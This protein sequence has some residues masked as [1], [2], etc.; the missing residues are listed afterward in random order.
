MPEQDRKPVEQAPHPESG[1]R[2]PAQDLPEEP[3]EEQAHGREQ[4]PERGQERGQ[5]RRRADA[6]GR[7][8]RDAGHPDDINLR[9]VA[10][11]GA[12]IVTGIVFAVAVSWFGLGLLWPGHGDHPPDAVGA[13]P[14][15]RPRLETA[16]QPERAAYDREK[17]Q[18]VDGYGWVDREAGI[19]RIPVEQAM[20]LM[21]ARAQPGTGHTQAQAQ[22]E[23]E[24]P[25]YASARADMRPDRREDERKNVRKD[26]QK[27]KQMSTANAPGE[28]AR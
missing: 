15:A 7:E 18:L 19:A 22:A 4:T 17:A 8:P 25:V 5:E 28:Q 12:I 26:E 13:A 3:A 10:W 14:T 23:T 6:A 11:G 24:T 2:R 9:A 1:Q 21:A 27:D 16:P 20:Q